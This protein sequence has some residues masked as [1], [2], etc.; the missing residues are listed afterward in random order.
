VTEFW[1]DAHL[2][3]GIARWIGQANPDCSARAIRD[4]GLREATDVRIFDAAASAGAVLLT[5]DRDF[6]FLRSQ[7][8]PAP[9][10]VLLTCGN[11]SNARL[12]SILQAVMPRLLARLEQGATYLEVFD[13]MSLES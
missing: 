8:V 12:R 6:A 4:L 2:S 10:I 5:K 13:E 7:R 9:R 11:T 3:P 1:I